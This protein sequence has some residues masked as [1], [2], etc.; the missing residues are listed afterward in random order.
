MKPDPAQII[1]PRE[2]GQ[3]LIEPKLSEL[4][5]VL[6]QRKSPGSWNLL[7]QGAAEIEKRARQ[8]FVIAARK[9]AAAIGAAFPAE[10]P[11]DKPWVIT[12]H[13]VEFFH[14]G[15][16]A[17]MIVVD[18][19]AKQ[20][21]AIA[22]DLLVDH[23]TV[24]Q[25]GFDVPDHDGA[26]KWKRRSV[27]WGSDGQAAVEG[28][29]PPTSAAFEKWDE[30]LG[31]Q[32]LAH[33]DSLGFILSKLG[34]PGGTYTQWMSRAR[35][36]FEAALEIEAFHVPT[37]AMCASV[38]W[39]LFVLA[40]MKNAAVW[41]RCY[42][43][44]L[45]AYRAAQG[46]HNDHH[47]MP[48]LACQGD[49]I[50][51]PFWIY[52]VGQPRERLM[53][54][55]KGIQWR[56]KI[57]EIGESGDAWKSAEALQAMLMNAGLVIRPRALTL[58]MYVRLCLSDLFIHGIG[59]AL[60][61]QITDGILQE[62]FGDVPAYGVVSAAWLLPLGGRKNSGEI[63]ELM[64]DR[65]HL[66]HNPQLG[67]DPFTKLKTDYAELIAQRRMLIENLQ[68]GG[69]SDKS[70]RRDWF[71]QLHATNQALHEKSPRVL[72]RIDGEIAA[73]RIAAEQNKVTLWREYYFALHS[74]DSLRR[75]IMTI[76]TS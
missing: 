71:D 74:M 59:G 53:V 33:T 69:K 62:L 58:T 12:G 1:V 76:R 24:G 23:D 17:K 41:T 55:A 60:Y 44:Q 18:T 22:F 15:V 43:A 46:I 36:E 50:E 54:T 16:W 56:G 21:G 45:A 25:F 61:D 26:G 31:R 66:V 7:G 20:T 75:L 72:Q 5:T 38:T 67:I 14:A 6:Q 10:I 48:D 8:E 73:A 40:W 70:Q 47:P 19:L 11:L 68:S 52:Q 57:V 37:S 42:N 39:H 13:Q 51:L 30:E 2:H 64:H 32:P 49:A 27:H 9:H 35:T 28:A 4:R 63:S 34:T 65:H 29:A 3:V